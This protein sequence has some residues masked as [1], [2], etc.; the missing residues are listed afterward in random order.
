MSLKLYEILNIIYIS[1]N[2]LKLLSFDL[3]KCLIGSVGPLIGS[4]CKSC[5]VNGFECNTCLH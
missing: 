3:N 4:Q 5:A 2:R 1:I